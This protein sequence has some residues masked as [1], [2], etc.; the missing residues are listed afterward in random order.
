MK[1]YYDSFSTPLGLFSVAVD[2]RGRV[3]GTAF[4]SRAMLARRLNGAALE[5]A[6]E[7]CRVAREQIQEFLRG[8]RAS[9]DLP[10]AP[11]GT[12]FQQ[13]VWEALR[14]IPFGSTTS[15][16]ELARTIGRPGAARAVGRANA[17]N[18]VCLIVPCHRVIGAN[19]SLTGFA[20]GERIKRRL[21][22]LE[23]PAA[24]SRAA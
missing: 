14:K 17:T 19:G 6:E 18:P 21:L 1:F 16:G 8:S 15:Y 13:R 9:F 4:G 22:N 10:L 23:N 11:G 12:A 2:D 5:R 24:K 20:F 7:R 3:T